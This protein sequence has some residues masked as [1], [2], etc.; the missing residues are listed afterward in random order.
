MPDVLHRDRWATI[1]PASWDTHQA[2][3]LGSDSPA[4]SQVRRILTID[5]YRPDS[6]TVSQRLQRPAW[7]DAGERDADA[8]LQDLVTRRLPAGTQ[9]PAPHRQAAIQHVVGETWRVMS[10]P[11]SGRTVADALW[12]QEAP[13][14]V[15]RIIA[16]CL[17]GTTDR[18]FDVTGGF[19]RRGR[20]FVARFFTRYAHQLN[21]LSPAKLLRIAVAAGLCGLD[22]KGGPARCAPITLPRSPHSGTELSSVWQQLRPYADKSPIVDHVDALLARLAA[23][24]VHLVWWLDDLIETAFDLLLIQKLAMINTRLRVTI[25]GK[26]GQ[27]DNDASTTDVTEL[28]GLPPLRDLAKAV[29]SRRVQVSQHG[30]RMATANPLKLH[31]TLIDAIATSDMMFC[32]GGRVHEMFSG[33]INVPMVTGYV[34]VRSFTEAQAGVDSTTAP[35]M[36]FGAA[37]GTWPWWGFQGRAE[38]TLTLTSGRTIPACYTTVAEHDKRV[39]TRN[40]LD[41]INDLT[42]LVNAW[43]HVRHRYSAPARAEIRLLH[44][45]ITAHAG[46][47]PPSRLPAL[48]DARTI[49]TTGELPDG[50]RVA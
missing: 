34:V 50:R 43:P 31:P 32:K 24:E 46:A 1:D 27:Y 9:L 35:L 21:R 13:Y 45:R 5:D 38:R 26:N 42:L 14:L 33:T 30:P 11:T 3:F 23:G 8:W 39:R 20:D 2:T 19:N 48:Q 49:I 41:L 15:D 17:Y 18:C 10:M 44:D 12:N 37:P 40:P 6:F 22:E 16:W 28:I 29:A 25:V 7:L 36:I 4:T 47:L